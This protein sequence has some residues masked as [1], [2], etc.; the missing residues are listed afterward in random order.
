M[1]K[2]DNCDLVTIGKLLKELKEYEKTRSEYVVNIDIPDGSTLN[3]MSTGLDKDG[4][5]SI[6]VDEDPDEGYYDVQTLIDDLEHYDK[7][8]KVYMEGCGL[9]LTF[10]VNL[11]GSLLLA[12]NDEDET[13]GFDAYAF[14]EYEV[15]PP[16]ET[17][18]ESKRRES[19]ICSF[20]QT[21]MAVFH[22]NDK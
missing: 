13:V 20:L 16:T 19:R 12:D 1:K 14:G 15:V 8:T 9:Y 7:D 4:D 6:E 11:K 10:E 22:S 5:L 18:V 21:I 2:T 17:K 3:V